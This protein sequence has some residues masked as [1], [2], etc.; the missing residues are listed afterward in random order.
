MATLTFLWKCQTVFHSSCPI[1]ESYSQCGGGSNFFTSSSILHISLCSQEALGF[2][3]PLDW[4]SLRAPCELPASKSKHYAPI[5]V[6]VDR[7]APEMRCALLCAAA[8]APRKRKRV[9]VSGRLIRGLVLSQAAPRESCGGVCDAVGGSLLGDPAGTAQFRQR[10]PLLPPRLA[11]AGRGEQWTQ[12]GLWPF[13]PLR[14]EPVHPDNPHLFLD[15][16]VAALSCPGISAFSSI[17]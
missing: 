6:P 14:P 1:L 3:S 15:F 5:P 17:F 13:W 10:S 11:A 16:C 4:S 8:C 7:S 2:R 12:R 9:P